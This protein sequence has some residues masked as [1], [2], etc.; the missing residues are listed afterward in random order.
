[1]EHRAFIVSAPRSGSTVLQRV[2][3]SH[4]ELASFPE[5]HFFTEAF[6]G[7]LGRVGGFLAVW[8]ALRKCENRLDSKDFPRP[9]Q[10]CLSSRKYVDCYVQGLDKIAEERDSKGWIEK[11]PAH[12]HCIPEIEAHI[13]DSSFIH[14]VRDGRA[15]AASLWEVTNEHRDVWGRRMTLEECISRWNNDVRITLKNRSKDN[16][17]VVRYKELCLSPEETLRRIL[18]FI[19]VKS[20]PDIDLGMNQKRQEPQIVRDLTNQPWK[21]K[22]FKDIEYQGLKKWKRLFETN[23]DLDEDEISNKINSHLLDE[24]KDR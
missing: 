5:T 18:E 10:P 17:V 9:T 21:E 4:P 1:M 14:I 15:V 11:T 22:A 13:P 6:R 7:T 12:L 24:V 2:L 20:S 19:G 16:H 23:P 3:G 8:N